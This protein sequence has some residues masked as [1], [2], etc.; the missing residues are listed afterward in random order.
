VGPAE[1]TPCLA[2][3]ATSPLNGPARARHNDRVSQ[4]LDSPH[5]P[6]T[7]ATATAPTAVVLCGGAGARF[8]GDKTRAPLGNGTVLD[9][10][11]DE[12]PPHWPV[13]CVGSARSTHRTVAWCREDPPGGGP[14]AGLAAALP[15][16]GTPLVVVLGGDMP[17]AAGPAPVLAA[18]L[19]A[20]EELDAVVGRDRDGRLQPLLAAYRTP[21][22]GRAVPEPAAGTPLMRLLDPL[23]VLVVP[24]DDPSALDVDTPDDL[25]RA[26]LRLGP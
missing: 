17:Y 13:I 12:L 20:E 22:L 9:H 5:S 8:G 10:L 26:R 11:L 21:A 25:D 4:P 14:V 7:P 3:P 6:G 16:V 23:R 19:A 2:G 1:P 15:H 18:T 24:L